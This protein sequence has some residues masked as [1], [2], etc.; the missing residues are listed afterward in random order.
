MGRMEWT[1]G[2]IWVLNV[3]LPVDRIVFMYKYVI[4]GTDGSHFWERGYNRICDAV[5]L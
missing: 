1:E 5:E 4:L 2:D 3:K